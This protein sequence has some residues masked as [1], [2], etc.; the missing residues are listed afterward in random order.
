MCINIHIYYTCHCMES[1]TSCIKGKCTIIN[2][3]TQLLLVNN[4]AYICYMSPQSINYTSLLVLR[5]D[6]PVR[7]SSSKCY[8]AEV[9]MV[10]ASDFKAVFPSSLQARGKLIFFSP[11]KTNCSP[12]SF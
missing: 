5:R 6:V 3:K 2:P 12:Q 11:R 1:F 4:G 8:K 7:V 10:V 9:K